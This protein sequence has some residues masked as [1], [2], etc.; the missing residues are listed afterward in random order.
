MQIVSN[1]ESRRVYELV[2]AFEDQQITLRELQE[3]LSPVS[4][5]TLQ[6]V[7]TFGS[8]RDAFEPGTPRLHSARC[9]IR[10]LAALTRCHS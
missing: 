2:S 9:V 8:A 5:E 6:V 1:A 10:N 7:V 3:A 4:S